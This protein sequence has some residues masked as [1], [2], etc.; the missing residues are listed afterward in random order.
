MT[1][2][3]FTS[4]YVF[5]KN[6][7]ICTAFSFGLCKPMYTKLYNHNTP[8]TIHTTNISINILRILYQKQITGFSTIPIINGNYTAPKRTHFLIDRPRAFCGTETDFVSNIYFKI[9]FQMMNSYSNFMFMC[10]H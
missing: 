8:V 7:T 4:V 9:L 6:L 10:R 2:G 3:E 1:I 5:S